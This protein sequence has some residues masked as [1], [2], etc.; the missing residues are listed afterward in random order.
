MKVVPTKAGWIRLTVLSV[1]AAV[2]MMPV[3][4][5][6]S[7]R[8]AL[9][10]QVDIP[11]AQEQYGHWAVAG[12]TSAGDEGPQQQMMMH[13]LISS[14]PRVDAFFSQIHGRI[15]PDPAGTV[16]ADYGDIR[17]S[18]RVADTIGWD[19]AQRLSGQP[20]N[21]HGSFVTDLEGCQQWA[22]D[23]LQ[24]ADIILPLDDGTLNEFILRDIA[25]KQGYVTVPV[26]RQ[27]VIGTVDLHPGCDRIPL[28][29]EVPAVH[30]PETV[31]YGSEGSSRGL[32]V[33]LALLDST[34]PG[35]LTGGKKI[36]G[37]GEIRL[38]GTAGPVGE[39]NHK[40]TAAGDY[41][42]F[43]V[44]SDDYQAAVAANTHPNL[45]VIKVG[46][47]SEALQWLCAN[48]G[49]NDAACARL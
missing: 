44:D 11:Q 17:W 8:G 25:E 47:S 49:D 28:T 46:S 6:T 41:D 20:A 16:A 38:D 12:V 39:V 33:T 42:V 30:A 9:P 34:T 35:D 43:L 22:D 13:R 18:N 27:G 36:T 1:T 14:N 3:T 7:T 5:D 45:D 48:G 4:A 24:E 26:M 37:T 23:G 19:V 29:V 15:F 10:V 2:L 32:L 21:P 31:T 40:I